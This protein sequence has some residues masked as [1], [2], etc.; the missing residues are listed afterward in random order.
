MSLNRPEGIRETLLHEVAH[1]LVSMGHGA[2]ANW[3]EWPPRARS[4][5]VTLGA[6]V[7]DVRFPRRTESL[8]L[9]YALTAS[10]MNTAITPIIQACRPTGGCHAATRGQWTA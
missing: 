9:R 1:A 7:M 3:R 10:G 2:R 8:A 4:R 5:P 6:I